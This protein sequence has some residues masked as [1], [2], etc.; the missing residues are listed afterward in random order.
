MTFSNELLNRFQE[1]QELQKEVL[2]KFGDQDYNVFIFGS[3]LTER[4]REGKSDVDIVIYAE[5][6]K[7]YLDISLYFEDY[8]SKKGIA[9]DIFSVD[10]SMPSAIYYPSLSS[11]IR[12]TDYYPEKLSDFVS[13]CKEICDKNKE[14]F[15]VYQRRNIEVVQS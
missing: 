13:K 10:L 15:Y 4:Y 11:P 14:A 8:F 9:Q 6:Y 3:Y 7:K 1:I 12:F 5:N 2:E